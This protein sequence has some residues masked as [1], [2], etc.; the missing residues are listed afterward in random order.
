[1]NSN[2]YISIIHSLLVIILVLGIKYS[3]GEEGAEHPCWMF[4]VIAC[5]ASA[6]AHNLVRKYDL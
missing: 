5:V 3:P 6:C 2:G 4:L 1:M